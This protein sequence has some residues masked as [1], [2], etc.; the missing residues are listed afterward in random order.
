MGNP[1]SIEAL[2]LLRPDLYR[3]E[4]DALAARRRQLLPY[5]E[6][7]Y[8][9]P[10]RQPEAVYEGNAYGWDTATGAIGNGFAIA[11]G[12]ADIIGNTTQAAQV[13]D[14][15]AVR[16]RLDNIN[17]IGSNSIMNTGDIIGG[18]RNLAAGTDVSNY[19]FRGMTTRDKVGKV[20]TSAFTGAATGL[21]VGGPWG[22]AIGGLVGLGSSLAGVAIGDNKAKINEEAARSDLA[23]ATNNA[24]NN[25]NAAADRDMMRTNNALRANRVAEGGKI[26]TVAKKRNMSVIDFANKVKAQRRANSF[27]EGGNKN[28]I[29]GMNDY[30]THG[31]IFTPPGFTHI[32]AGGTH[33]QNRY[34]GVPAGI[35]PNGNPNLVEEG[36]NIYNDYV[37]SDRLKPTKSELKDSNI[38]VKY[39]GK[40][41]AEISD[42]L[43]E[44]AKTRPND[45]I[46]NNGVGAMLDRL[47][48]CQEQHKAK[49]DQQAA[50]KEQKEMQNLQQYIDSLD[51]NQLAQLASAFGMQQPADPMQQQYQMM[52]GMEQQMQQP[53][54]PQEQMA[55]P[56]MFAE[57]GPRKLPTA[58]RYAPVGDAAF[59]S[60]LTALQSPDRTMENGLNGIADNLPSPQVSYAPAL[61]NYQYRPV[62]S[63]MAVNQI[64]ANA[65]SARRAAMNSGAGPA[66]GTMLVAMNNAT[67]QAVGNNA[68][69]VEQANNNA[70]NQVAQMMNANELQNASGMM[71]A[72]SANAQTAM[73]RAQMA[74][75]LR[76]NALQAYDNEVTSRANALT[77]NT[78]MLAQG[79]HGIGRE[80]FY[81]NQINNDTTKGYFIGPDGSTYIW[82][83]N[84]PVKVSDV[85][86]FGCNGGLL[87]KYR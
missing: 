14:P 80:N 26:T 62:D 37:F 25:L 9:I 8:T 23:I 42:I 18:Y 75:A 16:A 36:E 6:L 61:V 29:S 5:G 53:M 84:V 27:A 81:M 46:S 73:N 56:A 24:T 19:D 13:V 2:Q 43:M 59:K 55:Q 49:K 86:T 64:N 34:G 20:G 47:V 30:S 4:D 74:S 71:Q 32:G 68:Y 10:T 1:K 7:P 66:V 79:L 12:L 58:M 3:I 85:Q 72:Q 54:M 57:G 40:S 15:I 44:E 70:R 76:S 38:P 41:F 39:I 22:A 48:S 35:D 52:P 60:M 51:E 78:S 69:T 28:T 11:G 77:T 50:M 21:Q 87:K 67:G 83:N 63:Q 65:A 82:K 31:A 45:P 17:G 33:E